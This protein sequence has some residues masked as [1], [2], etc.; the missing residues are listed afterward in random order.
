MSPTKVLKSIA[1]LLLIAT[2]AAF[3]WQ[4]QSIVVFGDSLSDNGNKYQAY[5]IPVSPPY[6]HGRYS[7]GPVWVENLAFQFNL[8]PNPIL[9]ADYPKTRNFQD[10]AMGD[11]TASDKYLNPAEQSHS[12]MQQLK[13]YQTD[14]HASPSD[15][16]AIIWIGSNDYKNTSCRSSP[17]ICTKEIIRTQKQFIERLY[18]FGIRHFLIL[19]LPNLAITPQA[20]EHFNKEERMVLSG[21][22]KYYNNNLALLISQLQTSKSDLQVVELDTNDFIRTIKHEFRRPIYQECYANNDIYTKMV[23]KACSVS[24]RNQ[25]LFWDSTHPTMAAHARLATAAYDAVKESGWQ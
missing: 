4:P 22:I 1:C 7:N 18:E 20:H 24:V 3:A 23:G 5:Q 11:A 21:L 25:Y 19:S 12:L 10:Y 13:E 9:E 16:L 2:Q 14:T 6:W 15:T 8:I 17:F